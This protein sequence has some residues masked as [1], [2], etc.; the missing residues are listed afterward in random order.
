MKSVR[1]MIDYIY[2]KYTFYIQCFEF[3][4]VLF[5]A[6]T[7]MTRLFDS[8]YDHEKISII[9]LVGVTF[10]PIILLIYEGFQLASIGP[11]LMYSV[12]SFKIWTDL[13]LPA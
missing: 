11:S 2:N 4:L 8:A 6:K 13:V 3:G 5:Q 7:L 9:Q 10:L 12:T 1:C